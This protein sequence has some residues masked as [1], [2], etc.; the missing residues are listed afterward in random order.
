MLGDL[1]KRT[2][3]AIVD[4]LETGR[5]RGD[6]G[7]VTLVAGDKG[8]LSY[9]RPQATLA[10]GNLHLLVDAYCRAPRARLAKDLRRYLRK[11]AARDL[12]LDRD[13]R[14]RGLLDA[15]GDDPVM[16]DVQDALLD[17]L[18]WTPS[19]L[20]ANRVGVSSALGVAVV[21]DSHVHGSW[22]AM[23]DRTDLRYG[24][25][26]SIGE[27]RWIAAYVS[28]RRA[29]LSTSPVPPLRKTVYRMDELGRMIAEE[30]WELGLPLVVRGVRIDLVAIEGGDPVRASAE[31]DGE[32]TLLVRSP[33][34]RGPDVAKVQSALRERGIDLR[35]AGVYDAATARAVR[36]FQKKAGLFVDGIVGPA[37]RGALEI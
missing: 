27:R 7:R 28:E 35:G 34:L 10:S 20:A 5:A 13:V 4:V 18:W 21:Y 1:A 37:T 22:R 25:A 36:A 31:L 29:W 26:S 6:Y 30:R 3:Q 17:R 8:H 11:L 2:A 19:I 15:A 24:K 33:P 14:L 32:R 23:C 12:A 9:G 16:H